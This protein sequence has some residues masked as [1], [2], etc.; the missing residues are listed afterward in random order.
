MKEGGG[1]KL[2]HETENKNCTSILKL[3]DFKTEACHKTECIS[4]YNKMYR[5]IIKH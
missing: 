2:L 5:H 4:L 1:G 3:F